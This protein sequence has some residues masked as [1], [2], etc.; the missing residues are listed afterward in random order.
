VD[1]WI[2]AS[3][4]ILSRT[5]SWTTGSR[6]SRIATRRNTAGR[7]TGHLSVG[8]IPSAL[9]MM[10]VM[11][12]AIQARHPGIELAVRPHSS[13]EI[14]RNLEDFAIDVTDA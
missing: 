2:S 4:N 14:L 5:P 9:P 13:I 10:A 11:T 3:F 6:F 1:Q 12:K 8:V 7:L